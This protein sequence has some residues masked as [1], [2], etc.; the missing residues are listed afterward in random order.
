M[1]VDEEK[2][3]GRLERVADKDD[4]GDDDKRYTGNIEHS[5]LLLRGGGDDLPAD[6][7]WH[8]S[9]GGRGKYVDVDGHFSV[10]RLWRLRAKREDGITDARM[11]IIAKNVQSI[12]CEDCFDELCLELDGI[13]WDRVL[14][15]EV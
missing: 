7:V 12:L 10:A 9:G 2:N 13:E 6:Q 4:A 11:I 3:V 1:Q 5:I 15:L 8:S 14:P